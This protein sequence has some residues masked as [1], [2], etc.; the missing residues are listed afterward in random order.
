VRFDGGR[1]FIN[2]V[3]LAGR[4]TRIGSDQQKR[5]AILIDAFDDFGHVFKQ[6]SAQRLRIYR[7]KGWT[8][9]RY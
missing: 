7:Q 4:L 2:S 9:E 5:S 3:Q 8:I 6:R 1:G